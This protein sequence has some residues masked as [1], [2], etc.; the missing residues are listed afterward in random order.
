MS[1]IIPYNPKL[2]AL[3]RKLRKDMTFGEVLL[4]NELKDNKVMG[5]DFDRQRC[6]D[7]FI[8]DFYCKDLMLA[9]EIDGMSHNYEEAFIKDELRQQKLES[10]GIVFIRFSESEM[11]NDMPNVIRT[12]ESM[13]DIVRINPKIRLPKEFD[14]ELLK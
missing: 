3:A 4:W 13:I 14:L 10:F 9:I 2:K 12:I 8:V 7:N 1:R 11:K 5:F 6:I